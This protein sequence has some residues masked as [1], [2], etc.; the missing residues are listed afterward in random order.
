MASRPPDDDG[1][2]LDALAGRPAAAEADLATVKEGAVARA[3]LL[4]SQRTQPRLDLDAGVQRLVQ[5]LRDEK[6]FEK[7]RFGWKV[8]AAAAVVAV[9]ISLHLAL[10]ERPPSAPKAPPVPVMA[11]DP[12]AAQ[13]LV[14]QDAQGVADEIRDVMTEAGM[15]PEVTAAGSAT[16][17]EAPWPRSPSQAQLEFLRSY[18]LSQPAGPRLKIE[19]R[20]R[21]K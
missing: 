4:A 14:A 2:W 21:T 5:R 6:L 16:R 15:S 17:F 1:H 13:V 9:L 8:P 18:G 11:G 3:A 12:E 20:R 10:R 19:V 7:S